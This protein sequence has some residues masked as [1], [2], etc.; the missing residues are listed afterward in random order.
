MRARQRH[1][2][3]LLA[4][5]FEI[6]VADVIADSQMLSCWSGPWDDALAAICRAYAWQADMGV[7]YLAHLKCVC[8]PQAGPLPSAWVSR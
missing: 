4:A 7:L 8:D 6:H 5:A 3:D 2:R 1:R